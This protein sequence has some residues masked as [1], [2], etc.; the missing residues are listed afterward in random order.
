[1]SESERSTT[2]LRLSKH[3]EDKCWGETL[4]ISRALQRKKRPLSQRQNSIKKAIGL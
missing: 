2:S 1:M 4:G 3:S